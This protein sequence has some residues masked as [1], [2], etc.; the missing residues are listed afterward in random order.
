MKKDK[1]VLLISHLWPESPQRLTPSTGI[2]VYEQ[3][4]E[5]KKLCDVKIFVP[6]RINPSIKEI[7]LIFFSKKR[8]KILEKFKIKE[9]KRSP[10]RQDSAQL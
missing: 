8:E 4:E 7:F 5:L 6:V 3:V 9:Q 1:K 2:Y 10:E